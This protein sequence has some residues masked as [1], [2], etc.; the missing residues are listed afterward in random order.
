MQ[1]YIKTD[2]VKSFIFQLLKWNTVSDIK[3][4]IKTIS[5]D[6]FENY[7][8][9]FVK[10]NFSEVNIFTHIDEKV[11]EWKEKYAWPYKSEVIDNFILFLKK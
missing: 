9:S 5:D 10:A 11:K 8:D 2:D 3:K 6:D 7:K 4:H 1:T